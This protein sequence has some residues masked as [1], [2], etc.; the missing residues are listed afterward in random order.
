MSHP[1]ECPVIFGV[2]LRERAALQGALQLL[3]LPAGQPARAA[4]L[5]AFPTPA[6]ALFLS[7]PLDSAYAH[8]NLR[9]C[10]GACLAL[11]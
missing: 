3:Q 4:S 7:P 6:G 10:L 5:A 2:A 1:V 8:A 9:G 11:T